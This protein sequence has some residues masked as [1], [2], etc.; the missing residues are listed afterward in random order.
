MAGEAVVGALRAVLGLDT[1]SFEEGAKKAVADLQVLQKGFLKIAG[2]LGAAF[3][4]AAITAAIKETVNQLEELNKVSQKIGV[5]VEEL[6]ALKFAAGLADISLQDLSSSLVKL[7]KNMSEVAKGSA[8]PAADAFRALGI[9][10]QNTDGTLRSQTDVIGDLADAFQ[11][12][13]DSAEKTALSVAIFGKA[14]AAMIPLLNQGR[15]GLK[16]SADEA[17]RFGLII[18]GETA[19]AAELFNDNLKRLHGA[20]EGL[21][22]SLVQGMLP[23]LIK[24]TDQMVETRDV[25]EGLVAIGEKIGRAFEYI[26]F[27]VKANIAGFTAFGQ[28][29]YGILGALAEATVGNFAAAM[30]RLDDGTK[31]ANKTIFEFGK[32]YDAHFSDQNLEKIYRETEAWLNLN[33]GIEGAPPAI[34]DATKS[35]DNFIQSSAD[36]IN[37]M[38][39]QVATFGQSEGAVAKLKFELQAL[40]KIQHEGG[41]ADEATLMRI[42]GM[43]N[44]V[45]VLTNKLVA[46]GQEKTFKEQIRSLGL[47]ARETAGEFAGTLAPGLLS[48]AS[49]LKILKEDGSN[50]S[51]VLGLDR[52]SVV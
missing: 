23:S 15:I 7:A 32:V 27:V 34:R 17:K 38:R 1:A 3:S 48:A 45:G 25:G 46:L 22:I 31:A 52:K 9:S 49:S 21:T 39:A 2:A 19:A 14:G 40:A 37:Q 18:D 16:Q 26:A 35:L 12:F 6:S 44:E 42:R 30:K 43:A 13:K 8:G 50:L 11:G 36:N 29:L 28:V 5:P 4:T 51:A 47:Q 33:R 24:I 20:S 41:V 10:V